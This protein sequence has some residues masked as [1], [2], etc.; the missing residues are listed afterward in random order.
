MGF[1]TKIFVLNLKNRFHQS[2]QL[3][4]ATNRV[5]DPSSRNYELTATSLEALPR[6]A[7]A[8]FQPSVSGSNYGS[9]G[10][11]NHV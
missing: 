7:G 6:G 3:C 9:Y 8:Y 10:T 1:G 2:S 11:Q 5:M 4:V